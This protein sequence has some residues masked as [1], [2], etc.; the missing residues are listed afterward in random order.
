MSDVSRYCGSYYKGRR[1]PSRS[2]SLLL[3]EYLYIYII[4]PVACQEI[5]SVYYAKTDLI[6]LHFGSE[7]I[8][9]NLIRLKDG[10]RGIR[11]TKKARPFGRAPV[12]MVFLKERR[13]QPMYHISF[14]VHVEPFVVHGTIPLFSPRREIDKE[15]TGGEQG[16]TQARFNKKSVS[17]KGQPSNPDIIPPYPCATAQHHTSTRASQVPI[18]AA[19]HRRKMA[20]YGDFRGLEGTFLL[21][22]VEPA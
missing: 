20:I 7:P 6:L 5:S 11:H 12:C 18:R 9:A 15:G 3:D 13:K 2:F 22:Y 16:Q 21:S 19:F 17:I 4:F 10:R 1:R 8:I 14:V